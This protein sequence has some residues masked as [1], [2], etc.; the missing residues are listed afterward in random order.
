MGIFSAVPQQ[1]FS[2]PSPWRPAC[3]ASRTYLHRAEA[4]VFCLSCSAGIWKAHFGTCSRCWLKDPKGKA[5][6]RYV[7]ITSF[8]P[9]LDSPWIGCWLRLFASAL[10]WSC[11]LMGLHCLWNAAKGWI[12]RIRC[13]CFWSRNKF[14]SSCF[15]CSML[16]EG[17]TLPST[18]SVADT[19]RSLPQI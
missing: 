14:H 3:I 13:G 6:V 17:K 12:F 5:W 11:K 16:Q 7:W 15:L 1:V 10:G 9:T 8:G 18:R 4:R 19:Q 2:P